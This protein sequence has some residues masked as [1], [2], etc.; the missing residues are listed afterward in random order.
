[1]TKKMAE[2]RNMEGKER[3]KELNE[4]RRALMQ[5]R[6]EQAR[7]GIEETGEIKRLKR[8]IARI[9]TIMRENEK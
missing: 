6:T 8:R 5:K 2:I 7:G 4:L 9:L 1:M 3:E